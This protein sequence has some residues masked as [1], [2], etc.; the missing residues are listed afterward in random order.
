MQTARAIQSA[1]INRASK[2]NEAFQTVQDPNPYTTVST[3]QGPLPPYQNGVDQYYADIPGLFEPFSR[4]PDPTSYDSQISSLGQAMDC[5]RTGLPDPTNH[6][7]TT[8][9]Q[10]QPSFNTHP[11]FDRL[12]GA[13]D[14]LEGWDSTA[15]INFKQ[16][17]LTPFKG[18]VQDQFSLLAILKSSVEAHKAVWIGAQH[19]ICS[20]AENTLTALNNYDPNQQPWSFA[21]VV[22]G[23]VATISVALTGG[24]DAIPLTAIGATSGALAGLLPPV[25]DP[26]SYP[27]GTADQ[28]IN[29]MKSAMNELTQNIDDNFA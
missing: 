4:L 17:Y 3:V 19:D 2:N 23:V 29:G 10:D 12:C 13:G 16:S 20:I 28:I 5:L 7:D 18:Y 8:N 14:I 6:Q 27:S 9:S 24:A 21:F 15:A 25:T 1:A 11:E 22:I 26:R